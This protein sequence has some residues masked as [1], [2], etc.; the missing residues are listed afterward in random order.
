MAA[1]QH[2]L[3]QP[4]GLGLADARGPEL[5]ALAAQ[6]GADPRAVLE[7]DVFGEIGHHP[8][9]VGTLRRQLETLGEQG[10]QAAI[11]SALASAAV[12]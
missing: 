10:W 12:R 11:S 2:C 5:Q 3:R 9:V 6:G 8:Q 4:G 1:W 7:T